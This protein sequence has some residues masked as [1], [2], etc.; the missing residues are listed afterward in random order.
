MVFNGRLKREVFCRLWGELAIV[1]STD[2][3]GDRHTG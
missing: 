2:E 1:M 3:G